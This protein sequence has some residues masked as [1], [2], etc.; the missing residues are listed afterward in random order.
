[1]NLIPVLQKK[2]PNSSIG[3]ECAQWCEN[4]V[5][6]GPVGDTFAQKK[7]YVEK[8]GIIAGNISEI[9]KGFRIGDIVVTSDGTVN[10]KGHGHVFFVADMDDFNLYAAESNYNLDKRVH[11]GRKVSKT[12]PKIYG[13]IRSP[14]KLNLGTCEINYNVFINN[15]KWADTGFLSEITLKIASLTNNLLKVNFFPLATSFV[16]WWYEDF[17]FGGVDYKVIAKAYMDSSPRLLAFTSDNKPSD[18][19]AFVVRDDQWQGSAGGGQEFAWTN[20][21][22]KPAQIQIACDEFDPSPWYD[23]M[24]LIEHAL[25]H[26]LSHYLNFVNGL[27]DNTDLLDIQEHNLDA[28]LNGIDWNRVKANV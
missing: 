8:N 9:G 23:G 27:N 11:Y 14:L 19:F 6:F 17:S 28:T 16:N 2:Y 25:R 21:S 18:V 12:D 15:Q 7:A 20:V 26:E 22:G 4:L 24:R 3:G 10:G 1:M 13:I 5:Q